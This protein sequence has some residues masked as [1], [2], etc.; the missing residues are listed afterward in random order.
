V[1]RP[2]WV[3]GKHPH[4]EAPVGQPRDQPVPSVPVP[5]AMTITAISRPPARH[6]PRCVGAPPHPRWPLQPARAPG[7]TGP[8]KSLRRQGRT[9][10]RRPVCG[11]VLAGADHLPLRR[12][13]HFHDRD[14][15]RTAPIIALARDAAAS[16][17]EVAAALE[18][19]S[20][21]RHQRMTHN[22]RGVADA[23]L[24]RPGITIG[25]AAD[26][27]WTYSSPELYDLLVRQRGRPAERYGQVVGQAL[28]AA[29]LPPK[30]PDKSDG[31]PDQQAA[32]KAR[33]HR[34]ATYG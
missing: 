21:A 17:P 2:D 18:Q 33:P 20:A 9:R 32:T 10:Q 13:G 23:G 3:A 14:R 4:R 12:L 11:A 22:A 6:R 31:P 27:L 29:L 16:D 28:I 34:S 25:Q 5:P 1:L 7:R 26:I 19:I 8:R 15:P 30:P 24:L